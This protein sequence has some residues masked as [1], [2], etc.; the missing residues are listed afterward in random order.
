MRTGGI[1]EKYYCTFYSGSE[2]HNSLKKIKFLAAIS[3]K[4]KIF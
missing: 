1:S 3:Y 4:F 2:I